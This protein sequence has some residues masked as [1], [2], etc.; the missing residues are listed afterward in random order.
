MDPA[1]LTF[2]YDDLT[3]FES[4]EDDR[5]YQAHPAEIRTSYLEELQGFLDSTRR[6]CLE[7]RADY[8]LVRSDAELDR[9]LVSLLGRRARA[10]RA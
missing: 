5:K 10:G 7:N 1:E 9:V 3:Q 4:M 6:S 8:E 2:P